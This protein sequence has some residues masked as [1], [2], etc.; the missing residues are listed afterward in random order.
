MEGFYAE[1][2][3]E[4]AQI[5]MQHFLTHIYIYYSHISFTLLSSSIKL[6]SKNYVMSNTVT[7]TITP[8]PSSVN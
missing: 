3:L 2:I 1:N 5:R 7:S 8:D 4:R 6:V